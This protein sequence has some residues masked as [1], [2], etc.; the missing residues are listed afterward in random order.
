MFSSLGTKLALRKAGLGNIKTDDLF[1]SGN[2]NAKGADEGAGGFANPFANVQWGVPKALASWSTPATPQNPV[3]QP[4]R[5]GDKA[6]THAKLVFPEK[7]KR[8]CIILFLRF[9][10][11]PCELFV[12]CWGKNVKL[13]RL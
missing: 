8:P 9:C 1:G 7:N 4:P 12:F 2:S 3:R 6:Q 10:G 13:T 5:I 11:C